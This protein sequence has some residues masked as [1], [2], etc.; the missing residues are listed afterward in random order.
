MWHVWHLKGAIDAVFRVQ[1]WQAWRELERNTQFGGSVTGKNILHIAGF[2]ERTSGCKRETSVGRNMLPIC[3]KSIHSSWG[4]LTGLVPLPWSAQGQCR[5][6]VALILDKLEEVLM[7]VCPKMGYAL[8]QIWNFQGENDDQQSIVFFAFFRQRAG[9]N[10]E[11]GSRIP[12]SI[13]IRR[14]SLNWGNINVNYRW[15]LSTPIMVHP[16][17]HDT[18]P[19]IGLC[20]YLVYL[21]FCLAV[22]QSIPL[23]VSVCLCLSLSVSVCLC[24]SLSVSV[25][26]LPTK[27]QIEDVKTKQFSETSCKMKLFDPTEP[28]NIGKTQCFATFYLFARLYLLSSLIF[29]C[30]LFSSLTRPISAFPSIHIVGSLIF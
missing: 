10:I 3:E 1:A 9:A 20:A 22:C 23:S 2:K 19:S 16:P 14:L 13:T 8:P 21:C 26:R 25:C 15:F 12:A 29:L 5:R 11:L 4:E 24:L 6:G 18:L 17:I 30:L 7:W 28:Q 27:M